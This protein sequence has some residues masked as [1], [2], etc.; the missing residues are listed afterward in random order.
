MNEEESDQSTSTH[1]PVMC[2]WGLPETNVLLLLLRGGQQETLRLPSQVRGLLPSVR[3]HR[4]VSGRQ[5][6]HEIVTSVT[7]ARGLAVL[8][9]HLSLHFCHSPDVDTMV[10]TADKEAA[11]LGM[12]VFQQRVQ[13]REKVNK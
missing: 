10:N 5:R 7:G 4:A 8:W 9:A 13:G 11:H 2:G 6:A 12:L 3:T 1:R